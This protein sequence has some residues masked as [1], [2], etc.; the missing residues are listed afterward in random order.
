MSAQPPVGPGDQV[1][2]VDGS[3]FVFRAYF[4]SMNQ[5]RKYNTRPDGLPTGAVR[6]FSTKLMQFIRDG[7]TGIKPTHLAIVFDKSESSFRNELYADYKAHRPEPPSDLVPQ[8]RLMRRA[9]EAFGLIPIE[10]EGWE[11]DDIIATYACEA[12]A[13]GAEVLIVSSDKDLMQIVRPG[14]TFYDFESGIP[15]KP[16]YRPERRLDR[17]G[18]IDKFGVPPER[19]PDVQ[20][21]IGDPTDNVP[22]VPGIGIK[23]AAQLISEFGDL[24]T[25]LDRV[26]EIKQPK[27]REALKE[28]AEKARVSKQLVT[29]ECGLPVTVPLAETRLAPLDG[30]RLVAFSKALHLTAL[31]K[32][33]ADLYDVD[34]GQVEPDPDLARRWDPTS[35]KQFDDAG[36][37]PFAGEVESPRDREEGREERGSD[38]LSPAGPTA[39]S[40]RAEP[41]RRGDGSASALIPKNL[42]EARA[43][44]ARATPFDPAR[45]VTIASLDDLDR[46]IGAAREHGSIAIDLQLSSVDPMRA[47][48][49]GIAL[50]L[51]P[52]LA[53]YVP[54]R[55]RA[56]GEEGGEG[57]FAPGLAPDQIGHDE[58]L[59]RLRPL[60]E[61]PSILKVGQNLKAD[62]LV[63]K[64]HGIEA[65]NL[66]DTMLLSYA[67]DVG[68][69]GLTPHGTEQLARV[70]LA[71]EC[72]PLAEVIGKGRKAVGFDA[73]PLD[74]ATAYAAAE[75]DIAIRLWRVLKPRLAPE[76]KTTLYATLERPMTATLARME[77]RG[78]AIDR[79]IL[80]RMSGDFAQTI[81]R[82]EDEVFD[83]AGERFTIGS[84][85]QLADILFGKFGLPGARKTA[86]G[87]WSTGAR[88]LE[89][90]AES[91]EH[92]LPRKILE[93]RQFTRLKGYTDDLPTHINP[94]TGRVHTSYALA[95]TTTGRLSS[96]DPNL[97]NIPIRTEEGRKIRTAFVATPGHKLISADYSQ[98]ELRLLADIADIPQLKEAFANGI[99]I[100]ARTASEMFDVPVEGMPADVR[101][102]AKAIN[103]GIVYGISAFGLANQLAIPQGEAR[104]YIKRYFERFP[105]IRAYMDA[106]KRFCREAGYVKTLFGRACHY[107][108]I[109]NPN[110][111]VRAA[112][113]RQAINAPIQGTAADI[114]RRAMIRMDGALAEAK[115]SA[116]MLLTVHDEL[117]FEC[118]D[119]E[120]DATLPVITRVMEEAPGPAVRLN[121]PLAVE[122]RAGVNWDAAH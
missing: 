109:T 20:A 31:T 27:R 57:L 107:P 80:S 45:Y 73:I 92:P 39:P 103:F 38:A 48:I 64:R 120:V 79:D 112:V 42:V 43:A 22:G 77:E 16:G 89:D 8:F 18:V 81:A 35:G 6:L 9:V 46:W 108:D 100:H 49:V 114:I 29:L 34:P 41:G 95:S 44:E 102:R 61:D 96:T 91:S 78:I 11:A 93:W 1:F 40:S 118:R 23:T 26:E 111:S 62:W 104:D 74:R 84:P 69:P 105:G 121:V 83:I 56:G 90:L 52:G 75:A 14:V 76:R 58:A 72:T 53:G 101:R 24:E 36:S 21:L 7:A 32:R 15:G 65:V 82:V 99:D 68:R 86:T 59:A 113:E 85:K 116:R 71:H 4:Q 50:A 88:L 10:Q 66:D 19:V 63:L 47:E 67:L 70:Y 60:L 12:S 117:V 33:V 87:Q 106:T 13:A 2:L 122:A 17:D 51:E 28:N 115:L 5:D 110:A 37:S 30:K 97:Q 55:H 119:E 3:S 25:L 94:E 54:L 98:I